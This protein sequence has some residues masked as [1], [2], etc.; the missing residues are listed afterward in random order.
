M[1][2]SRPAKP[3]MKTNKSAASRLRTTGNGKLM[4]TNGT[5]RA[6]NKRTEVLNDRIEMVEVP[7]TNAKRIRRLIPYGVD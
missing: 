2:N 7:K 5:R 3:K 4:R 1:A 6:R